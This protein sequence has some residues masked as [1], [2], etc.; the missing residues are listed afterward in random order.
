VKRIFEYIILFFLAANFSFCFSQEEW[1]VPLESQEKLSS[2]SFSP[3]SESLGRT[4]YENNCKACHGTPGMNNYQPLSP[5][6]G[7]PANQ[8]FQKNTDGELYYKISEGRGQMLSFKNTLTPE[9]I[10]NVVSYIRSFNK[11]YVQQVAKEIEKKGY[12]GD[13]NFFLSYLEKENQVK[14][15]LVGKKDEFTEKL[16]G[17][18]M[19]IFAERRFGK[20]PLDNFK[21]T[22]S[23]GNAYFSIPEDL[24]GDSDGKID[25]TIQLSDIELFGKISHDTALAI[26]VPMNRPALNAER[27]MWNKFKKAPIWLLIAYFSGVLLAWGVIFYILFQLRTIFYLGK[28]GTSQNNLQ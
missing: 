17:V 26:G 28:E 20:L 7:D 10:W 15:T 25:L 9:E 5:E 18:N 21:S 12:E 24:P 19:Q 3:T 6:P 23:E 14:V 16:P 13:I 1:K 22:N 4:I 11:K 2:F 8:K 27:A